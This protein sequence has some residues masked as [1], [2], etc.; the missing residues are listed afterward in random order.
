MHA[1]GLYFCGGQSALL[2]SQFFCFLFFSFLCVCEREG[3]CN[4]WLTLQADFV[5]L[6]CAKKY[7]SECI[8]LFIDETCWRIDPVSEINTFLFFIIVFSVL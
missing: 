4:V 8:Y 3:A 2:K 5:D 7:F 1:F 6:T